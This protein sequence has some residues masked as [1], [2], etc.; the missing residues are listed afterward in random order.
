M[1]KMS[2]R[3]SRLTR[4]DYVQRENIKDQ[5]ALADSM[6]KLP[7]K[8]IQY[9]RHG[10]H[11]NDNL[12]NID[13]NIQVEGNDQNA[14]RKNDDDWKNYQIHFNRTYI[15][16][17]WWKRPHWSHKQYIPLKNQEL[18]NQPEMQKKIKI[19]QTL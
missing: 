12:V 9:H 19:D 3:I 13:R 18:K 5:Y 2:H 11:D 15:Q 10:I 16:E 8:Q 7:D 17:K 1:V 6:K 14:D 4:Y